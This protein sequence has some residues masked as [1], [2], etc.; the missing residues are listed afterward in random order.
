MPFFTPVPAQTGSAFSL[1]ETII[2]LAIGAL[3]ISGAM[4][5]NSHQLRLVK[6][7]REASAASHSMQERLEQVRTATW[8]QITD[9]TYVSET[10]F[11]SLPRSIAPLDRYR[12]MI[13]ISAWPE[14]SGP[15]LCVEKA[16]KQSAR[17]VSAGVGIAG[18]HLLKV[19]FQIRWGGG[20]GKR[21]RR[22]EL[23]T[24]ISN[25]GISRINLPAMGPLGGGTW[26][27]GSPAVRT[28]TED[29]GPSGSGSKPGRGNIRGAAGTK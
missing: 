1:P 10:L 26:E 2:A 27:E 23:S 9:P 19:D 29:A 16:P 3:A 13:T 8:S 20:E 22:R 4:A 15:V 17:I 28:S 7:T 25:G 5:V 12:E 18:Q 6:A 21:E 24:I 11:S 14:G